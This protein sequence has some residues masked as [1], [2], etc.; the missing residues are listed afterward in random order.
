VG[1]VLSIGWPMVCWWPQD[2]LHISTGSNLQTLLF[3]EYGFHFT[4]M[5]ATLALAYCSLS[6]IRQRSEVMAP[7]TARVR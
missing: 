7:P 1:D 5:I 3:I 2:N 6:L 4:L